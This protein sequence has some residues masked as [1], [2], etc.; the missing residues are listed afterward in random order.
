MWTWQNVQLSVENSVMSGMMS[1]LKF[2]KCSYIFSMSPYKHH[3]H[4]MTSAT[5]RQGTRLD[6]PGCLS[7][8]RFCVCVCAAP[9]LLFCVVF[10]RPLFISWTLI[11]VFLWLTASDYP[12]SIFKLFSST[13]YEQCK[14]SLRCIFHLIL[15]HN[16]IDK[17]IELMESKMRE[18]WSSRG[19]RYLL[20]LF[21]LYRCW[22]IYITFSTLSNI[23]D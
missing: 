9:S 13:E 8:P 15:N 23:M 14:I 3:A 6:P 11:I 1:K 16:I 17:T 20:L 10:Y 12:F 2:F 7:S 5:S 21:I 19:K 4:N 18:K 22:T